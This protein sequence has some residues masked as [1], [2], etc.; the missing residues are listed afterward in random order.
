MSKFF[1]DIKRDF[2]DTYTKGFFGGHPVIVKFKTAPSENISLGQSYRVERVE[3]ENG[4][5]QG[6]DGKNVVTLK[7]SCHA[8]QVA[9]K[10]KFSNDAAVYE[11]AYKPKDLNQ[12]GKAFNLKHNSRFE[13]ANQN[14]VSTESVKFGSK[15]FSDVNV[16]LNLDFNWSTASGADQ[17]LKSAINF[18]K[19]EINFGVK[20][21]YSIG[22][23]KAKSLLAQACFSAQKVD[24]FLVYDHFSRYLT[25][26]TLSNKNY[27]EHETHAC[28]LV[29][30]TANK[31]KWFYGYPVY[32]SWAGIYRLNKESTLRVK[33][34]LKDTWNLGFAWGQTINKNLDVN[35]SHDLDLT[36]TVG[37]TKSS[38]SPYNFGLQF[39]FAL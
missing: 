19:Q 13:T 35:F 14:V 29:V 7:A 23:Q 4:V 24:H 12:D 18:T 27:K 22:K 10:F 36:Q 17:V 33:L 31:A 37:S 21:D 39:R 8:K 20:S 32:S 15:L 5:V 25:Y 26:A 11:V 1:G 34:L 6:Y 30:D 2:N 38:R 16:G 28:D 9:T 3:D